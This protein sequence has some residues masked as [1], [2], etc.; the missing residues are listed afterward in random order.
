MEKCH[1]DTCCIDF[2]AADSKTETNEERLRK[3]TSE[4]LDQ[5]IKLIKEH[6]E[7]EEQK[8]LPTILNENIRFLYF[9][10]NNIRCSTTIR[11]KNL[12]KLI[13]PQRAM[14]EEQPLKLQML[15]RKLQD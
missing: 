11:K 2:V 14:K 12:D 3:P 13:K 1:Q 5:R 10:S 7:T 6:Q 4:D 15:D 9:T 8:Y